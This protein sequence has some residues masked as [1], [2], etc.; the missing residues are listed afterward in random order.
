MNP[1]LLA[2]VG[3]YEALQKKKTKKQNKKKKPENKFDFELN[4]LD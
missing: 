3:R 2:R 4:L 1:N